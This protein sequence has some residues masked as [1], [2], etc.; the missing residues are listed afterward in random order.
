MTE[1][2]QKYN[3]HER[4]L[5][6]PFTYKVRRILELARLV[7]H[8]EDRWVCLPI[9]G[10]N[11]TQYTLTKIEDGWSCSCQ[12]YGKKRTCSHEQAL[13]ETLRRAGQ[14]DQIDLFRN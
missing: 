7:K 2:I 13:M 10:Y 1:T 14:S 6:K 8:A 12:G 4:K 5:E 9:K 11:S 3:A